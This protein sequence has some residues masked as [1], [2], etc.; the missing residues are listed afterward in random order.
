MHLDRAF[1]VILVEAPPYEGEV[2][3]NRIGMVTV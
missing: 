1:L 2:L 3:N